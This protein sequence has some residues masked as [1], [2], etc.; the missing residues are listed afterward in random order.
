M[1]SP[2]D[3]SSADVSSE[4]GDAGDDVYEVAV[5][6]EVGKDLDGSSKVSAA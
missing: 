2:H 6:G 5:S 4:C 1:G 3:Y